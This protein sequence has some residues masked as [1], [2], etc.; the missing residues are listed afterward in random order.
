MLQRTIAVGSLFA[1]LGCGAMPTKPVI[2]SGDLD[3]KAKQVIVGLSDGSD[4]LRRVPIQFYDKATCL[5]PSELE[6]QKVYILLLEDFA[7]GKCQVRQ[8][9]E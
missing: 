5:K 6:K 8:W 3:V 7:K 9:G 1:L 2:E 4:P